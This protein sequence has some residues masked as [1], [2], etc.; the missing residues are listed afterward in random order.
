MRKF[1]RL[2]EPEFLATRWELWGREWEHLRRENPKSRFQWRKV[3]GRPVNHL[4]LPLLKEQTQ[5]HCSFCDAF[6][7][8]PPSVDTVEHLRPKC[9]FPREAYH[10]PNLYYCCA[11][12][13]RKG[14]RFDEALLRPDEPG[15]VFERYFDWDFTTGEVRPN[16]VAL[17]ADRARAECT[18]ALFRLNEGHPS[19]RRR[20]ALRFDRCAPDGD[21]QL[22]D[23]AYRDFLQPR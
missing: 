13:Q 2:P 4:L 19:L 17:Q 10:W 12:C 7:V 18:I 6:P 14:D 8:S 3:D 23:W 9:R 1:A 16:P 21:L 11:F 15:F 20:E 22:D 5:S